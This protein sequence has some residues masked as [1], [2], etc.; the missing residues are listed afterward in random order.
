MTAKSGSAIAVTLPKIAKGTQVVI[1]MKTPDGK[2]ISLANTKTT[3]ASAFAV[4]SLTLKKS[5]TY[6]MLI[7]V[8]KMTKTLTVK[9]SK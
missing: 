2:T 6:T 4:P 3:K 1:T 7:K 9:V 8:G 5:G